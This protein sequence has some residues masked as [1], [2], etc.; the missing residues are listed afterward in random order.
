MCIRD[1]DFPVPDFAEDFGEEPELTG[2]YVI[3]DDGQP[4]RIGFALGNEFSDHVV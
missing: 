1:R 4:Y 2:L 3:A